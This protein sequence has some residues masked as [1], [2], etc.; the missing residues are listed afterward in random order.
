MKVI[1]L[2]LRRIS[3]FLRTLSEVDFVT[4]ANLLQSSLWL[5]FTVYKIRFCKYIKSGSDPLKVGLTLAKPMRYRVP[6]DSFT[7]TAITSHIPD[8]SDG[9]SAHSFPSFLLLYT[10][11]CRKPAGNQKVAW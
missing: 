8:S 10:G 1:V 6:T 2:I 3:C 9:T 7:M 5:Q 11:L 4:V